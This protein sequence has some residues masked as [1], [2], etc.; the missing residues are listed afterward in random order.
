MRTKRDFYRDLKE[1]HGITTSSMFHDDLDE[2]I[3]DE[4]YERKLKFMGSVNNLFD[5]KFDENEDDL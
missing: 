1:K 3:S 2:Q 5:E 4:D